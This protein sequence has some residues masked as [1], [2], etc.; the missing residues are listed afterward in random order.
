MPSASF[1]VRS[2]RLTSV[3]LLVGLTVGGATLG[4][5]PEPEPLAG[6]MIVSTTPADGTVQVATTVVIQISFSTPNNQSTLDRAV[7]VQPRTG[8]P[9]TLTYSWSL[10]VSGLVTPG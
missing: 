9:P 4:S 1:A 10:K 6:P 2:C 5:G 8:P 7:I 3:L